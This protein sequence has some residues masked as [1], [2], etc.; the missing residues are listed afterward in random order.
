MTSFPFRAP[1]GRVCAILILFTAFLLPPLFADD[2]PKT[3][4]G[5][6]APSKTEVTKDKPDEQ[7]DVVITAT[8]LPEERLRVPPFVTTISRALIEASGKETLPEVAAQTAGVQLYD[9]GYPGGLSQL[10]LRGATGTR[11]L[12]LIDGVPTNN[13]L[14]GQMSLSLI[15]LEVIDRIEI[16][17][18]GMSLL[19]GSQAVGGVI[20]VI[21]KKGKHLDS[22]LTA[23]LVN[24]SYL[25]QEYS[26]GGSTVA[27]DAA[28]LF[29][30]ERASVSI[31]RDFGPF[32]FFLSGIFDWA[33]N[34]YYYD[35]AGVT[36]QR[37]NAG[38]IY[39]SGIASVS[40]PWETGAVNVTG[41]YSRQ[42]TGIPGSLSWLSPLDNEM[43]ERIQALAGY[44]ENRFLTEALTLDAKFSYTRQNRIGDQPSMAYYSDNSLTSFFGELSQKAT[45]AD[46]LSFQYGGN[47]AYDMISGTSLGDRSRTSGSFFLAAPLAFGGVFRIFPAGR[48][49]LTSDYGS[50][51]SYGLGA[52]WLLSKE[53]SLKLS[54][55]KSFRAPTFT[56]LYWP[57]YSNPNLLPERGWHADL[58]F[59]LQTDRVKLESALFT[60]LMENEIQVDSSWIPQNIGLSFYPG[61][62]VQAEVQFIDHFFVEAAYTFIYSFN[63]ASGLTFEDNRR[64]PRVPV[65]QG[66][67]YLSYRTEPLVVRLGADVMG[68]RFN[69]EANTVLMPWAVMLN[70]NV[71]WQAARWIAVTAALDN[72]LNTQYQL[73]YD[74]PMPGVRLRWGVQIKL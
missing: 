72:I 67:L 4:D 60:R 36:E 9:Y 46:W 39:G 58:G 15:P 24:T 29:D 6:Q 3:D 40:F 19:Y 37:D 56:D 8:R 69:D 41:L 44:H 14:D 47:I 63:L 32:G 66:H 17:Q 48:L 74:Y 70:A 25:P 51:L 26:S 12:V 52:S 42:L 34:Q 7:A 28:S 10:W 38:L 49:D 68:D 59:S 35:N 45:V 16:V 54:L 2:Q 18:G 53:A 20:N 57:V 30:G 31:G 65:H 71:R 23:S 73:V 64:V 13:A 11:V 61:A 1:K 50:E 33:R 55:A 21:T 43:D 22:F 5:T 62:E 27:A